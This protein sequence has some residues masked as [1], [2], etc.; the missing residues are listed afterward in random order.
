M[1]EDSENST[2]SEP[3]KKI[4][5]TKPYRRAFEILNQYSKRRGE[6][7]EEFLRS[8]LPEA[9]QSTQYMHEF[10]VEAAS[11]T[12]IFQAASD[13]SKPKPENFSPPNDERFKLLYDEITF[14][15]IGMGR[16]DIAPKDESPRISHSNFPLRMFDTDNS[17]ITII[18]TSAESPHQYDGNLWISERLKCIECAIS[19]GANV[20]SLGEF[21]FPID[22]IGSNHFETTFNY[23]VRQR[24]DRAPQPIFLVGG[25]R[26]E[27][28]QNS[29]GSRY[30]SNTARIY[31]NNSIDRIQRSVALPNPILHKKCVSAEKMGE[32]L[33]DLGAPEINYY[34]TDL[35]AI[36]LL[37]CVDAHNPSLIATMIN[38]R[39]ITAHNKIDYVIVPAYNTSHKMYYSCQVLSLLTKSIVILVDAC[40][41][42]KKPTQTELFYRGVAFNDILTNSNDASNLVGKTY[43]PQQN[44]RVRIWKIKTNFLISQ[45]SID[46]DHTPFLNLANSVFYT[47]PAA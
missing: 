21:D 41:V 7:L 44:S 11:F 38:N 46:A 1:G 13:F 20:I 6:T 40:S 32:R 24:I 35:G 8:Q 15:A 17:C 2:F 45:E 31:Y 43:I 14:A 27:M 28:S 3:L 39:Q 5:E 23:E 47:S 10:L 4:I 25:S 30:W 34:S 42:G 26:H 37:I 18:N 16:N 22:R 33:T 36:A 12:T 29:D 9:I 19:E